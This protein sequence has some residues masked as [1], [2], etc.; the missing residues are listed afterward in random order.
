MVHMNTL[1]RRMLAPLTAL[2][3]VVLVGCVDIPADPKGSLERIRG[4]VLNVGIS[5]APGLVA[6]TEREPSGPLVELVHDYAA[7]INATPNWTLRSEEQLVVFLE[8]ETLD[9]AVGG[10]TPD[11]PWMDRVGVTRP[12]TLEPTTPV[13]GTEALE[14]PHE[15]VMLLQPGENALISSVEEFLDEE[16]Q[17]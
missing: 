13:P 6:G 7:S 3:M 5:L 14:A 2:L 11:T 1:R 16:L 9:L 15:F 17:P 10:F 8:E 12:F 4:G